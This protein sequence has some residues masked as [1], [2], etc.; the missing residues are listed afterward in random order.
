ME[1]VC[2]APGEFLLGTSEAQVHAW[3]KEHPR[4]QRDWFADEQPQCRVR[5]PGYWIGRTEVTNAQYLEFVRATGRRAPDHWSGGE[6]PSGIER[7]PVV[8]V[9]WDD[10]RAYCDWAGGRLPSELEWEKAARGTGGRIFPWGDQ[11]DRKRC[12]NSELAS[13]NSYV[14]P[15][16]HLP[17]IGES[18]S[19]HNPAREGP[20]A[21]G[22]YPAGASP[23]GCLDMAGNVW[24]WCADWWDNGA[25]KRYA[26]GDLTSLRSGE[27]KVLRGGSRD[28]DAPAHYRCTLRH[29]IDPLPDYRFNNCGFRCVR[30]PA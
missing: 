19:S 23:Y 26:Q 2:I 27:Y 30:G 25:Y 8:L 9:S 12:R 20:V 15:E 18:Q 22:S 17:A 29:I 4:D 6:I 24:E 14:D 1:M 21:V 10:A 7:F 11:W 28:N 5:L 16:G 3:I 13:G